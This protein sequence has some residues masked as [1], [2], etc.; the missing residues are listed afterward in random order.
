M[1]R[2]QISSGEIVTVVASMVTKV[3]IVQISRRG[4]FH[5]RR[6]VDVAI[7][8]GTV[9]SLAINLKRQKAKMKRL[10]F[11][12]TLKRVSMRVWMNSLFR[13]ETRRECHVI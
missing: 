4:S 6:V 1:F 13:Y 5:K 2:V 9:C 10:F 8:K 3:N 11:P 7:R 12:V